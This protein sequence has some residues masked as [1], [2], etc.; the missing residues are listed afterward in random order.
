MFNINKLD[1]NQSVKDFLEKSDFFNDICSFL[2]KLEFDYYKDLDSILDLFI[3]SELLSDFLDSF[4]IDDSNRENLYIFLEMLDYSLDIKNK[5]YNYPENINFFIKKINK[6]V[7]DLIWLDI[8]NISLLLKSKWFTTL[9]D[10]DLYITDVDFK[11]NIMYYWELYVKIKDS[12]WNSSYINNAWK[13]LFDND[14]KIIE[15]IYSCFKFLDNIVF[16]FINSAWFRKISI[17]NNNNILFEHLNSYASS[18]NIILENKKE[19][20]YLYIKEYW[21]SIEW[22]VNEEFIEAA[23][24]SYILNEKLSK[25]TLFDLL[26]FINNNDDLS[27]KRFKWF[28]DIYLNDINFFYQIQWIIFVWINILIEWKNQNV[29]I[30]SESKILATKMN[31]YNWS[32]FIKELFSEKVFLWRTFI[33]F[34]TYDEFQDEITE[35]K[36]LIDIINCKKDDFIDWYIDRNWNVL[37]YKLEQIKSIENTNLK[38]LWFEYYI[39]N[40][41]HNVSIAELNIIL[42]QYEWFEVPDISYELVDDFIEPKNIITL[43]WEITNPNYNNKLKW[44]K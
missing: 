42:D 14:D 12:E 36:N 16:S 26:K 33:W 32:K 6:K 27:E 9:T 2:D 15:K 28:D 8:K 18:W 40:W 5:S 17:L 39:I 7:D 11:D 34:T 20:N 23:D 29:I 38:F 25:I 31:N 44:K 24:N 22:E 1:T 35:D 13:T 41:K 37:K 19:F 4:A 3:D 21:Y 43:N 10:N 30:N